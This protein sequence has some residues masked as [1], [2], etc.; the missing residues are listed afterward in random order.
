MKKYFIFI[1]AIQLSIKCFSQTPTAGH[2]KITIQSF[3]CIN[4]SWDGLVEFDGHGNEVFIDYGYR[5]YNPSTPGS[6]KAGAGFTPVFGSN[7]NGQTKAGTASALGGIANGNEIMVNTPVLNE[8]ID[9]NNLILFSPSVW[10]W[11]NSN[12]DRLNLFNQQLATDLNWLMSQPYPFLNEAINN[13]D[14]FLGRFIKIGDRYSSY[15]PILKYNE[16]LKPLFNVQDNRPVGAK[17]G[18]FN[19]ELMA[20]YNPALLVLDT[21][22]LMN[23]YNHNKSVRENTH[24][25]RGNILSGIVEM[26]FTESTY[27]IVTSNGSYSLK[28]KIEF[29]PDA[30]AASTNGLI[31]TPTRITNTIKKDMPVKNINTMNNALPVIG[32]WSGIQTNDYGLYPQNIVFELTGNGEYLIKDTKGVLAAKGNYTFLNNIVS[33]SY[34]QLSSGETFSFKA[35]YDP[36]TGKMNGT[37]GS[38]TSP[39]GQGKWTVTKY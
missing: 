20:L 28:L 21:R 23:F 17:S 11:D 27:A 29:T 34:K 16:I 4:Q 25:E 31:S 12:N 14:P 24:P 22:A 37:L 19:G 39:M 3:K 26:I 32:N 30:V 8:H 35:T 10:E 5:I 7:V 18:P 38:G 36:G 9:A 1:L 2:L 13:S 6:S 33:G 15:W